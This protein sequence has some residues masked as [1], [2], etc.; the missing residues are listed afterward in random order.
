M[1]CNNCHDPDCKVEVAES[2][3]RITYAWLQAKGSKEAGERWKAASEA[4]VQ[5]QSDCAH[6]A[7]YRYNADTLARLA[8]IEAR[9]DRIEAML[10]AKGYKP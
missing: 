5:A 2:T 9:Q 6:R 8:A 1:S 3:E 10:I 4:A 7:A